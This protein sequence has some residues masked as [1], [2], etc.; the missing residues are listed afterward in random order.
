[1]KALSMRWTA[2]MLLFSPVVAC[3][4]IQQPNHFLPAQASQDNYYRLGSSIPGEQDPASYLYQAS[5]SEATDVAPSDGGCAEACGCGDEVGCCDC[6]GNGGTCCWLL[7]PCCLGEPYAIKDCLVGPCC[8]LNVGGWTQLG[9]HSDETRFSQDF[10]DGLAFNDVPNGLRWQ[11]QWFY[12][13]KLAEADECRGDWGFRF[14]IMYGTDAQKTQAFGNDN[15]RW[16]HAESFDHGIYG[17]AMPQAYLQLAHGDWE[18]KIGHFFTL[19]G[20]EVIPAPQNFFYSHAYTMFNTEPFTHTGVISSYNGIEDITL[21]AGWTLGWDTGFDQAY[22]GSNWLGGIGA[23]LTDDIKVTWIQT[24][25]DFGRRSAGTDGYNQSVVANVALSD[26]MEYVFQT[27][28][29]QSNG[30][31]DDPDAALDEKGV[32]Q[33]LFYTLNDC[34]KLG[35]R[36]EWW[37]SNAFT[38]GNQ[39]YYEITYGVNYKAH[40]NMIIRPEIR[41]NWTPGEE[42]FADNND[43]TDFNQTVFGIDCILTY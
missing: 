34:W 40:A 17:W 13:E 41:H 24:I 35:L 2:A 22:G 23:Q 30:S 43:G 3:A 12:F 32:N 8:W 21:Y 16:D 38:P 29:Y 26:N 28:Y 15:A 42:A 9:Y 18:V 11:Q 31:F 25:G 10:G 14:D 19:V 6:C 4:E 1:M 5:S 27:D 39:S 7:G 20:Y 33:Y 36:A 37:K